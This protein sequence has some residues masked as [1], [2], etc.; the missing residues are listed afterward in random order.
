MAHYRLA[1]FISHPIHYLLGWFRKLAEE[2]TLEL[3]V[4]LASDYGMQSAFDPTS[5]VVTHWY[6][7]PSILDGINYT[8][9]RKNADLP[10]GFFSNFAPALFNELRRQRFDALLIRGYGHVNSYWALL[11]ARLADIPVVFHAETT[12]K[13]NVGGWKIATRDVIIR[14]LLAR[15]SAYMPI[16]QESLEFY[17]YYG[18][19]SCKLFLAPY[20]VD[21]DYYFAQYGRWRTRRTELRH[22]LG[23]TDDR[24]IILYVGKLIQRKCPSDVLEAFRALKDDAH[25]IYVGDGVLMDTLRE[26]TSMQSMTS[27]HFVGFQPQTQLPRYYALADIFVFP[28][29]YEAWGLVLNEAMCCELP[30]VVS[31]GVAAQRNLVRPGENGLVFQPGDIETLRKHLQLLIHNPDLRHTMGQYSK[32]IISDWSYTEDVQA[33]LQAVRYASS[34]HNSS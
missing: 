20:A 13:R 32:Q 12:L 14:Q 4:F 29:L 25:L 30:V 24:P 27:V 33:T 1:V 34:S 16:G 11:V 31:T 10:H 18:V 9:L 6:E 8:V 21:N 5:G 2:P 23:I 28:S 17:Q 22:E 19:P 3:T 15:M 26:T 7:D